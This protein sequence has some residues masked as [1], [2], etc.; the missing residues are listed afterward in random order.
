MAGI[1]FA[2]HKSFAFALDNTAVLTTLFN[3]RIY[4]HNNPYMQKLSRLTLKSEKVCNVTNKDRNI[5]VMITYF[6]TYLYR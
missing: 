3:R 6:T 2:N 5:K 1:Y 4:F